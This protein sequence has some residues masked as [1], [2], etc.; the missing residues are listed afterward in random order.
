MPHPESNHNGGLLQFGPDGLLYIGIG[1]GGG[2]GDQH[3]SR[4]NGQNLGIAA[5]Q[6]PAHRPARRGGR[7]VQ[8]PGRN[9]FLGR[10]GA[11]PEIYAYGLRNPWRF[12]FDRTTGDLVIGDVGQD[13]VEEVDF[14]RAARGRELRL[15]RVRGPQRATRRA[16]RRRADPA[17]DPALHS[18]GCCSITGGYV[19][20]DRC[21]PRCAAATSSA[22]SAAA[23]STARLARARRATAR[24][25][26]AVGQPVVV[27]R[28]RAR[29]V[30]AVSLDGPV[31]RLVPDDGD[32]AD[33]DVARSGPTTRAR[34]R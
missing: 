13:E 29:R 33:H 23:V 1:D 2:G 16:S 32:L 20:R 15:A 25:A 28:G 18:D 14:V 11:R 3:G 22:T 7:A 31:Y 17:G 24:H 30:Y 4:G 34:S 19:V 9:P 27:R 12:S 26:A 5:R 21:S 6:D 8:S 10:G